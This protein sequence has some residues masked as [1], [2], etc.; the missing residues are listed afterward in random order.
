MAG[1]EV[2]YD[3][4]EVDDDTLLKELTERLE[5]SARK[6]EQIKKT[7]EILR[8]AARIAFGDYTDLPRLKF[9]FED[10]GVH[11]SSDL[12]LAPILLDE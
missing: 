10:A 6:T 4:S 2:E 11:G 12:Q 9:L 7:E 8:C 1:L 3:F 5:K